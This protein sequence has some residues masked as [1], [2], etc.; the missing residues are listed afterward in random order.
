MAYSVYPVNPRWWN[1]RDSNP[2]LLGANQ[3]H[4]LLCYNPFG[5]PS[6]I[7][8]YICLVK[9]QILFQLSYR[10]L[11]ASAESTPL[12]P[13]VAGRATVTLKR[14]W[15]RRPDSNWRDRRM[16]PMSDHY[17]TPRCMAWYRGL[18]LE[19][20]SE[21]VFLYS[22]VNPQALFSF[23]ANGEN[24]TRRYRGHNSAFYH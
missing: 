6:R 14:L 1:C 8:T 3:L 21:V 20:D 24:R 16:R 22:K 13:A 10:C 19:R 15:L 4:S 18:S 17:S 5:T 12:L 23:G 11:V 9:S 2:N 7:R